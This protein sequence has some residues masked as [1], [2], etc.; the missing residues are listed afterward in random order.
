MP[1]ALKQLRQ[2]SAM[3]IT[4]T[5]NEWNGNRRTELWARAN[6]SI[7]FSA[8]GREVRQ[9][10]LVDFRDGRLQQRVAGNGATLYAYDPAKNEYLVSDYNATGQKPG[11][12]AARVA[13]GV[14]RVGKGLNASLARLY[15]DIYGPNTVF[16][17]W[18]PGFGGRWHTD[19]IMKDPVNPGVS[20]MAVPRGDYFAL[21]HADNPNRRSMA[22][23]FDSNNQLTGIWLNELSQ[24]GSKQRLVEWSA[25]FRPM[26]SLPSALFEFLPPQGSRAI[27][28]PELLP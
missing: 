26:P 25:T 19:G 17:S 1:Q 9:V 10:E 28:G 24:V 21:F 20:Y 3:E 18:T 13:M 23:R 7:T 16:R 5:G 14:Q 11:D 12:I 2:S 6:V 27:T 15:A 4:L 22:F 8:S